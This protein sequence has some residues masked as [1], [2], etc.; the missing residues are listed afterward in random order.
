MKTTIDISDALVQQ[1]KALA[2]AEGT[3]LHK[4]VETGLR[5]VLAQRQV[6]SADFRLRDAS[7]NGQGLHAN[8][9]GASW[10]RLRDLAYEG[11]DA[12]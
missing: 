4:L 12:L 3:T 9:Q 10:D 8:V 6:Q 7:F 5:L 1:A 11:R 2:S